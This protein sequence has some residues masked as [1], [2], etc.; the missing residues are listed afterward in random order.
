MKLNIKWVQIWYTVNNQL[1]KK[2]YFITLKF[3]WYVRYLV[4]TIKFG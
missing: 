1:E 4:V 3:G 2:S